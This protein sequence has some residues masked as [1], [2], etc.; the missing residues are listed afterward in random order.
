MQL[1]LATASNLAQILTSEVGGGFSQVFN[2][3]RWVF[4]CRGSKTIQVIWVF[5]KRGVPQ[6]GWFIM[7]NPIKN[8]WFGGTTIFGNIHMRIIISQYQDPLY[9]MELRWVFFVV[10]SRHHHFGF[11]QHLGG[12]FPHLGWIHLSDES[13]EIFE[14]EL[15]SGQLGKGTGK[16][17][18][19]HSQFLFKGNLGYLEPKKKHSLWKVR[20]FLGGG[21]NVVSQTA[22]TP[23]CTKAHVGTMAVP[24][25]KGG[26]IPGKSTPFGCTGIG[27]QDQGTMGF[28]Q[29]ESHLGKHKSIINLLPFSRVFSQKIVG[30]LGENVTARWPWISVSDDECPPCAGV[31]VGVDC[32]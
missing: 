15:F 21:G 11:N 5:P 30:F 24:G 25:K 29:W 20:F 31:E 10:G 12:F 17:K 19:F 3:V 7:E 14:S 2:S 22:L 26:W 6:N 1:S 16:N 32:H 4:E 18:A 13:V 9:S 23:K 8:G 27:L 28:H